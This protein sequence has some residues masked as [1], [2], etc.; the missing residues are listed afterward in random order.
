MSLEVHRHDAPIDELEADWDRLV[1]PDHPGAAFRSFPW[2]AAFY[3]HARPGVEPCVLV[4]RE[5][6]QVAGILPLYR[7]S[8]VLGGRWLRLAGDGVVGSDF[9][10]VVARAADEERVADGFARTLAKETYDELCLDGVLDGDPLATRLAR[11]LRAAVRFR[12]VCPAVKIGGSFGDYLARRPSGAGAQW[13]RRRRWLERQPGFR[14]DTY[15]RLGPLTRALAELVELHLARWEHGS[16]AIDGDRV[17]RFHLEALRGLA[18]RGWA[19]IDIL[20]VGDMPV[21]ALYGFRHGN[22]Y[23]FY[24]AGRD[25]AWGQRSVGTVLLGMVLE[26]C[27]AEKLDEFDFLHGDESYKLAWATTARNTV[28]V[29]ASGRSAR[30]VASRWSRAAW[31]HARGVARLEPRGHQAKIE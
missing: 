19:R 1:E 20:S 30:A 12:S 15:N 3:R 14:H 2:I 5:A 27:F 28:T 11:R 21:A 29:R 13:A 10:G 16:T 8:S 25:P 17:E 23:A 22:R 9:L 24:Q 4:A 18:R 26:R 6:G 31:E 7:E